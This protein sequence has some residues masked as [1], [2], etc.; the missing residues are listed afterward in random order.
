[1]VKT[2]ESKEGGIFKKA[3]GSK[4]E[5][6]NGTAH[7]TSGGLRRD[8]LMKNKRGRIVSK[9]KHA[10]GLERYKEGKIKPLTAEEL[11]ELR[12]RRKKKQVQE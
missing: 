5:V 3:L 11:G 4:A 6:F 7:R 2:Y 1:M 9:K 10:A 12:S 8:D